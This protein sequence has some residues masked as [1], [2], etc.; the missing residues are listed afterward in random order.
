M[1]VH[2]TKVFGS[3]DADPGERFFFEVRNKVWMFT[4][5]TGLTPAEKALYGGSTVRR[6]ART[7]ARSTD[8]RTLAR[9]LGRGLAAGLGSRPRSNGA[10]LAAAGWSPHAPT[11]RPVPGQPF[12]LLLA[13]YGGDDPGFLRDAFTS[14]VQEQTR[15]P[16][17]VVLVQDG[18]VPDELAAT[19]A[20]A[21]RGR[22]RSASTTS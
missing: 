9:G 17:Q 20:R 8:R 11:C 18:P 6:W 2:K 15:R 14:S 7:F 22:A 1:V 10:V 5:S 21:G 13:V 19:I 12:S 16:D 3:T 4:R